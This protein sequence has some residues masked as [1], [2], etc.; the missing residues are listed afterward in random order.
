MPFY[1]P[2]G[3]A[4]VGAWWR[5]R[6]CAQTLRR[7]RWDVPGTV[8]VLIWNPRRL[9]TRY[10]VETCLALNLTSNQ[11]S[12][13]AVQARL[14]FGTFGTAPNPGSSRRLIGRYW[15]ET[16]LLLALNLSSNP[17]RFTLRFR[18]GWDVERVAQRLTLNPWRLT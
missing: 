8:L 4:G 14:E 7:R 15:T 18:R 5:E 9:I 16:C 10:W 2:G 17:Q 12:Y 1:A 11:A 6:L 3:S 13:P